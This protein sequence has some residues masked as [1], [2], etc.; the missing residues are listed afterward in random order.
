MD[1]G[2]IE[3]KEKLFFQD[4][5]LSPVLP[6]PRNNS[7]KSVL[8][9]LWKTSCWHHFVTSPFA[10]DEDV[11]CMNKILQRSS[12]QQACFHFKLSTTGYSDRWIRLDVWSL[13]VFPSETAG[14]V[15]LSGVYPCWEMVLAC[16]PA[17]IELPSTWSNENKDVFDFVCG[18][19]DRLMWGNTN[20]EDQEIMR[21]GP[22]A[23][24][25]VAQRLHVGL[26]CIDRTRC[27]RVE[28]SWEL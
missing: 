21:R 12:E 16:E 15:G 28:H 23:P 14:T 22:V 26:W 19:L 11:I 7:T 4:S 8:N 25:L 3:V 27:R 1:D 10:K 20:R 24:C 6:D 9:I 5:V 13:P 17:C 18:W 2:E